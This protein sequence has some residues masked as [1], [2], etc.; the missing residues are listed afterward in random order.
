MLCVL[1]LLIMAGLSPWWVNRTLRLF[2]ERPDTGEPV[3]AI[4][5]V[6]R[7]SDYN[8]SRAEVAVELWKNGRAPHIFMSGANDAPI[9]VDLAKQMGVPEKNV[10]GEA[11]AATTWENA[12]YTKRHMP[13]EKTA[14]YKPKILL[15]TDDLHTGRANLVYRNLGFEVLSHP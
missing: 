13:L 6:G 7:G 9:L 14:L 11:C 15:V 8:E 4:V 1:G 3:D 5:V 10:S 2:A 12:F